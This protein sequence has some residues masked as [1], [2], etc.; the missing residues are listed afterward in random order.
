MAKQRTCRVC[1][2]TYPLTRKY[3]HRSGKGR[4]RGDCKECVNEKNRIKRELEKQDKNY[5]P[6][7]YR[8]RLINNRH[9]KLG[10]EERV[11]GEILKELLEYTDNSCFYC[12]RPL[13]EL[14]KIHFDHIVPA[15]EKELG[16]VVPTCIN[17]N[18]SK[19]SDS[20]R[21]FFEKEHKREKY[22]DFSDKG[23]LDALFRTTEIYNKFY[24][25]LDKG[26]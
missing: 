5:N 12:S 9:R 15:K 3:F 22:G 14:H 6:L 10:I 24:K 19:G 7:E 2:R 26:F 25:K 1:Q 11:T 18:M 8:A 16:V 13:T 20:M 17:C 4:Y 23:Y 21:E